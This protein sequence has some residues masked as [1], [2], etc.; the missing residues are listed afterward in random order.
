MGVL[1]DRFAYDRG[2]PRLFVIDLHRV[3]Q[4]DLDPASFVMDPS[5]QP[6]PVWEEF[7]TPEGI[8]YYVNSITNE[9]VWERPAEMD[10]VQSV[11]PQP[12][13]IEPVAAEGAVVKQFAAEA[14]SLSAALPSSSTSSADTE[15]VAALPLS[16][17]RGGAPLHSARGQNASLGQISARGSRRVNSALFSRSSAS[18][19]TKIR[20]RQDLARLV[21]NLRRV[22]A[23]L[24]DLKI[25]V[26]ICF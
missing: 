25:K 10:A 19:N 2:Q 24:S 16:S 1:F 5:V 3:I 4:I 26:F 11:D 7:F 21:D 14:E 8:P 18:D 23:E 17:A 9:S 12:E 13:Q 20:T 22:E 6:Q 15:A